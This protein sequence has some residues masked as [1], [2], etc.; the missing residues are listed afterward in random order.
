MVILSRLTKALVYEQR[1]AAQ[2][3]A[4]SSES[5]NPNLFYFYAIAAP[6]VNASLLEKGLNCANQ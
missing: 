6:E 1:L 5:I 2:V 4:F 3:F